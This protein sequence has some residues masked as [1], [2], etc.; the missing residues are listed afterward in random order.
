MAVVADRGHPEDHDGDWA[1]TLHAAAGMLHQPPTFGGRIAELLRQA[2]EL[3]EQ[4]PGAG[5]LGEQAVRRQVLSVL[6]VAETLATTAR[7]K[8][9]EG[10]A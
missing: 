9:I 8:S 2:A 1:A 6:A 7:Q 3:A 5:E 4:I 10:R